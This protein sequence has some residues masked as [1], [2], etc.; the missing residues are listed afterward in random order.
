MADQ[1]NVREFRIYKPKTTGDGAASAWQLSFKK[2]NKYNPWMFFLVTAK[3][4]GADEN[5]NAKFNWKEG[6]LTVKLG[7]ADLGEIISLLEGRKDKLGTNGSL[8][9]QT[10]SG[11]NK[12]VK[13]EAS[14]YGFNLSVSAQDENKN[15]LGPVYHTI[16]HGEASLLLVLLKKAVERIYGW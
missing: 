14:D 9:H 13:M 6:A 3:Q 16:T 2:D 8:F 10:P 11:G 5:G 15:R 1:Q 4:D 12:V 7:D